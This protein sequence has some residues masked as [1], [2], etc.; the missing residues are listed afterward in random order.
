MEKRI[1]VLVANRPRLIRELILATF[2]D[3]PDIEIVGE[4]REGEFEIIA[5]TVDETQPEFLILGLDKPEARPPLCDALL[6]RHPEMKIL[7]V[8]DNNESSVFYWA[9]LDIRSSPLETS[10]SA[11]LDALRGGVR[12]FGRYM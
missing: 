10:E 8:A 5:R 11:I 12:E 4:I 1:R 6:R 7:A 2:A 3:Q 9:K